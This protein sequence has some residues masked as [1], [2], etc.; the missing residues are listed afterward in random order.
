MV[1]VSLGFLMAW[2]SSSMVFRAKEDRLRMSKQTA[3]PEKE[4]WLSETK[5]PTILGKSVAG[6]DPVCVGDHH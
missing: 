5:L 1:R 3:E 2:L 4:R 6:G